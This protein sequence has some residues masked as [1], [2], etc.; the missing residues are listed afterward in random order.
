M[1]HIEFEFNMETVMGNYYI[2]ELICGS[3]WNSSMENTENTSNKS[4]RGGQC[5]CG[6]NK[7]AR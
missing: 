1:P 2:E 5:F 6:N 7:T 3:N 4:H